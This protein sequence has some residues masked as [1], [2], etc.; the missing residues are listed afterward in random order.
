MHLQRCVRDLEESFAKIEVRTSEP[1][2][3][4]RETATHEELVETK[5]NDEK[6]VWTKNVIEKAERRQKKERKLKKIEEDI[7]LSDDEIV[8]NTGETD[9]TEEIEGYRKRQQQKDWTAKTTGTRNKA[10]LLRT[11]QLNTIE[12]KKKNPFFDAVTPNQRFS[13]RI[14]TVALNFEVAEWLDKQSQ[15]MEGLF[16]KDNDLT[17]RFAVI[18]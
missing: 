14:R 17:D 7:E 4:F 2:V 8:T 11:S 12:I 15:L 9:L 13:V 10:K 1:L 6:K 5:T 3:S 18:L 16:Y